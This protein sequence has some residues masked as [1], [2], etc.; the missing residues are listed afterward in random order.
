MRALLDSDKQRLL[1]F[2][3][4]LSLQEGGL[5]RFVRDLLEMFPDRF[6]T[7][8]MHKF[9]KKP[10]QVYH[11]QVAAWIERE[12]DDQGWRPRP[13]LLSLVAH[14]I[15][16]GDEAEIGDDY[17]TEKSPMSSRTVEHFLFLCR[18]AAEKL[19]AFLTELCINPGLQLRLPGEEPLVNEQEERDAIEKTPDLACRRFEPA[20][21]P[22]FREM[23]PALLEFQQRYEQRIQKE[24]AQTEIPEKV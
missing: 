23:I 1:Y 14:S 22:F 5:K 18:S 13:K 21:V 19:D 7:P 12:L 16:D 9:G 17:G 20:G 15:P 10:G 11:S 4:A 6:G 8:T 24:F 3:Q 2:I